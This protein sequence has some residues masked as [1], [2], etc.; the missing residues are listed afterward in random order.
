MTGP[1]YL[2][3]ARID[4]QEAGTPAAP[5][6]QDIYWSTGQGLFEKQHVFIDGNDLPARF[7]VL[8]RS[9][10]TLCEIGFGFG[11][12]SLLTANAF[13]QHAGDGAI[14]NYIAFE[15]APVSP[16][17][18]TRALSSLTLPTGIDR[19]AFE[20]HRQCLQ[21]AW[22]MPSPG[23]HCRWIDERICL[24]LI[25]GDVNEAL[26]EL[27]A[28]VDAWFLDGFSPRANPE[29]WQ[30]RLFGAMAERSRGGATAS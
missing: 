24:T 16:A 4:W 1:Y 10:F 15:N 2:P 5:A 22:P 13:S 17:D 14:L 18:L 20:R 8:G 7:E 26:P 29:A 3:Y 21:D 23:Y 25:L 19:H 9:H 6:Y 11:L 30:T 12:N 27:D 28:E